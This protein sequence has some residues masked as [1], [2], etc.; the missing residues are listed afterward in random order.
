MAKLLTQPGGA[1]AL[2][3]LWNKYVDIACRYGLPFLTTTPTRRARRERVKAAGAGISPLAGRAVFAKR[4]AIFCTQALCPP[5]RPLGYMTNCV[6]PS[7]VYA[8]LAQPFN[9]TAMVKE[10]F[11]GL[12]ANTSSLTYVEL[13]GTTDLQCAEP[14]TLAEDTIKSA[15]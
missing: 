11:F 10:R 8:A 2:A 13:D 9:D 6:H 4:G 5:C 1:A 3:A 15:K 7:I 14:D 12:Q